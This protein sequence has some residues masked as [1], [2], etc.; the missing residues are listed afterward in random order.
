M[1]QFGYAYL[2]Y[3]NVE[4][5]ERSLRVALERYPGHIY[6]LDNGSFDE[7]TS[8]FL[9]RIAQ[10]ERRITLYR[11]EKNL[12]CHGGFKFLFDKILESNPEVK[13]LIKAD[14]S[15]MPPP[16]LASEYEDV[17]SKMDDHALIGTNFFSDGRLDKVKGKKRLSNLIKVVDWRGDV[18]N[19]PW[20]F[21]NADF[22]RKNG[23]TARYRM[24]NG[25]VVDGDGRLYGGEE[26]Y[27]CERAILSGLTYGYLFPIGAE[28]VGN[29]VLDPVY[30]L[31]KY[32]Y[33]YLGLT[34]D[35][36]TEYRKD[37][38][39]VREDF[40]RWVG[41]DNGMH[42]KWANEWIEANPL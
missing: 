9:Y 37:T 7:R 24:S 21:V 31:W 12:G 25:S 33:G 30:M 28:H 19:L 26:A 17:I 15:F 3:Q 36:F 40:Q 2:A 41:S 38:G 4:V 5:V 35:D 1:K 22:Y 32:V 8:L 27:W 13:W 23:I 39:S 42:R 14:D 16:L 10:A 18:I 20:G 6:V 34:S 11:S 29:D